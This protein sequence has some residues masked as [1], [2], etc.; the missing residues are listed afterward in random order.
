M[1]QRTEE[2]RNDNYADIAHPDGN[3]P[4]SFALDG[5][6][7]QAPDDGDNKCVRAVVMRIG[8]GRQLHL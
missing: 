4:G 5:L 8:H 2:A 6:G 7:S 1:S 3:L